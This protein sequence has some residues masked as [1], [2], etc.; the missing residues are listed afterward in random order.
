M[1][2]LYIYFNKTC[3]AARLMPSTPLSANIYDVFVSTCVATFVVELALER[4]W[5]RSVMV[6]LDRS[7]SAN[8]T[9]IITVQRKLAEPTASLIIPALASV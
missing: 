1:Q 4:W 5:C 9:R 7:V 2:Q 6:K 8:Y 3:M